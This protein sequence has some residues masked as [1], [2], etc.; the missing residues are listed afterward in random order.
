MFQDNLH[1]EK[2]NFTGQDFTITKGRAAF[3]APFDDLM[4]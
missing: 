2:S 1:L 4:V 3:D